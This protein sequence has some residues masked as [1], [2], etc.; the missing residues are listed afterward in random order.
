MVLYLLCLFSLIFVKTNIHLVVVYHLPVAFFDVFH[1][2]QV[3]IPHAHLD[4][5]LQ[6][7][8]QL[9]CIPVQKTFEQKSAKN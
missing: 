2:H 1:V 4:L 3:G 7:I 6:L 8:F 9:V 5:V